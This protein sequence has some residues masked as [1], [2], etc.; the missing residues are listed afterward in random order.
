MLELWLNAI[1]KMLIAVAFVNTR[2]GRYIYP[3]FSG[4]TYGGGEGVAT[5]GWGHCHVAHNRSVTGKFI[6]GTGNYK[7]KCSTFNV[8]VRNMCKNLAYLDPI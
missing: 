7:R 1:M 4:G 5:S 3:L 8:F 6:V 2:Y